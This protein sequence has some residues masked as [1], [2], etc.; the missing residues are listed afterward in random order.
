MVYKPGFVT[1]HAGRLPF[2][3]D[4][5]HRRPLSFYP[6]TRKGLPSSVGLHELSTSG[7]HSTNVAIGLVSPY[8]TFS[9]L[10]GRKG[11]P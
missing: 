10:P 8:L 5:R 3:Y 1:S 2:I 7:V 11:K 9:P 6:P 4:R